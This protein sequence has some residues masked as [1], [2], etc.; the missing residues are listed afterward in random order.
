MSFANRFRSWLGGQ[1][2]YEYCDQAEE[3][4]GDVPPAAMTPDDLWWHAELE[5]AT[6]GDQKPLIAPILP[7]YDEPEPTPPPQLA[8]GSGLLSV[9]PAPT[10]PQ[11]VV[12][13]PARPS[14]APRASSAAPKLFTRPA[15]AET[16]VP[17]PTPAPV[18]FLGPVAAPRAPAPA[19]RSTP[20]RRAR[21]EVGVPPPPSGKTTI[22]VL[23]KPVAVATKPVAAARPRPPA[24]PPIPARAPARVTTPPPAP[25][26]AASEPGAEDWDTLIARAKGVT[27]APTAPTARVQARP[28]TPA[29]A[30]DWDALIA[31]AKASATPPPKAAAPV[32]DEWADLLRRAKALQSA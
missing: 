21:T 12:A 19:P 13:P 1:K 32:E 20:V 8:V 25:A 5:A 17:A 9:A 16:P 29:G 7:Q 24:P 15:A 3:L 10:V 14:L 26:R 23:T 18:S 28:A 6:Q 22:T 31:Q 11:A 4:W 27:T 2:S 30:D